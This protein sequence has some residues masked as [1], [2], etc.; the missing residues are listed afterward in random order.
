MDIAV[1]ALMVKAIINDSRASSGIA[2]TSLKIGFFAVGA[3]FL[4]T[5]AF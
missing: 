5:L 4:K 1:L 3:F 2:W